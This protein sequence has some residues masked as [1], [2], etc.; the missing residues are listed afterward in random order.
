RTEQSRPLDGQIEI[1]L[2]LD[3]APQMEGASRGEII[4]ASRLIQGRRSRIYV[5]MNPDRRLQEKVS[6][7]LKNLI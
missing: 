4:H 6:M 7:P 5:R 3:Q 2:Q 1:M